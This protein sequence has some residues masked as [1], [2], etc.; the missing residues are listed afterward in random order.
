MTGAA[1]S[2]GM[3][4]KILTSICVALACVAPA[5]TQGS[6]GS[7]GDT[8]LDRYLAQ[9]KTLRAQFE[10]SVTDGRGE[11]VQR[12]TGRFVILRPGR[13]R[14]EVTQDGA[15]SAQLMVAD[16]KNLWFYDADLEQVSVKSAAT[17]LPSTPA[18]LL[19][20]EGDI[21][22]LFR[23]SSGGKRDGFDWVVVTPKGSDADFREARLGFGNGELKGMVLK[24]KLGQTV[25]L[26]F[27][28]SERN[29][30]VSDAEVKF[31]P[32]AGADV[33]GTPIS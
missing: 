3:R 6:A 32:P 30:P 23:V 11:T 31:T 28:S 13:F 25:R 9:L 24:D 7:S 29:A 2:T 17:A 22:E 1:V 18:S 33:I 15:T 8:P 26:Q 4:R 5:F 20:G 16:G 12:A 14:W 19:S 27:L 21:R 10:Q